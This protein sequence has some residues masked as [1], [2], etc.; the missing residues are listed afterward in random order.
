MEDKHQIW[1]E[2]TFNNII[3]VSKQIHL[4][5][6]YV[7]TGEN[8]SGKSLIRKAIS[9]WLTKLNNGER[10]RIADISMERRTGLHSDLG[11]MGVFL[12]DSS[13]DATSLNSLRFI[14]Q[15]LNSVTDRF[16]VLDEP[17]IGMG[18]NMQMS[19]GNYLTKRLPEVLEK[20]KGI[21][22]ITHSKELVKQLTSLNVGFL[23]LQNKDLQTWLTE[24][25][26]LI[27][28]EE[29]QEQQLALYRRIRK[30]IKS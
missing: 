13:D 21:L 2:T 23:N 22:I 19:I 15:I 25:P 6:I 9:E 11:G 4:N 3:E 29:W 17:E 16:V 7:L 8:G 24:E 26:M 5:K 20:N 14:Q 12:R 1:V 30:Q 27:D 28:L 10:V 18:L